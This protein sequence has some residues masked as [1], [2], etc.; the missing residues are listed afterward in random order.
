[1]PFQHPRCGKITAFHHTHKVELLSAL[2]LRNARVQVASHAYVG[3]APLA[4][5]SIHAWA[6]RVAW[7][8]AQ[9]P[10]QDM[11]IGKRCNR[12]PVDKVADC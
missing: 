9:P 11:R 10:A 6:V 5:K 12:P 2:V 8:G 3:N 1:M 7:F 4:E